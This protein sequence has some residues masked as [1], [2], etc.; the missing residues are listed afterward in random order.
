MLLISLICPIVAVSAERV[1]TPQ[2]IIGWNHHSFEG[3]TDYRLVE[4]G[5][6]PAVEAS[7]ENAS[8]SGLYLEQSIDLQATPV[9]EWQWWVEE[10]F[11]GTD[12]TTESGDDYP[13]RLYAVD[14]GGLLVWRTRALNY[15]WASE[16]QRGSDW[17]NP[18]QSQAHMIALRSGTADAGGRWVTERR[19]VR[20]DFS[21]YHDREL[22][23]ID[24]LA[25][26]TDCDNTGQPAQAWYGEIR[27]LPAD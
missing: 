12:E 7:C 20:E 1:F 22:T 10:T 27:L 19:N 13:A 24:A 9:I 4:K 3:E 14:R 17:P 8:A 2:D 6:Q 16:Q 26:M 21:T 25:I 15:V 23:E 18:F 11:T 5:G